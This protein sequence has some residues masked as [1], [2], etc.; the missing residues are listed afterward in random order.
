ML[1]HMREVENFSPRCHYTSQFSIPPML[2][3]PFHAIYYFIFIFF[4]FQR[5]L[6]V[7]F[8]THSLQSLEKKWTSISTHA[9]KTPI[10]PEM[11]LEKLR[12]TPPFHIYRHEKKNE[13][14]RD[15]WFGIAHVHPSA[16]V[17]G[18]LRTCVITI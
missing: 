10:A 15:I 3:L 17:S 12:F 11:K 8:G 18:T 16:D 6:V 9:S 14:T 7:A 1:P 4:S 2:F 13:K 5:K